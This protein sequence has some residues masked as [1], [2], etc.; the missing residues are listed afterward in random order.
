MTLIVAMLAIL[1]AAPSRPG[2]NLTFSEEFESSQLD[3]AHFSARFDNDPKLP[4]TYFIKDG[5]LHLRM[6][7]NDPPKRP[8]GKAGRVSCI[9][10]RGT[11]GVAQQYGRFEVRARSP[12][13]SGLCAGFWL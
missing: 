4:A 3:A 1:L 7:R 5:V 6:D 10:T 13:G 8:D 9:E 2:W 11:K 12:Q